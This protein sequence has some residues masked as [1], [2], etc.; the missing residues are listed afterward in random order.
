[1]THVCPNIQ[2][3]E[4]SVR[5]ASPLIGVVVCGM[6]QGYGGVEQLFSFLTPPQ[7]GRKLLNFR[8]GVHSL[9]FLF[10]WASRT[11]LNR[12][13]DRQPAVAYPPTV[14][15][16][17]RRPAVFFLAFRDRPEFKWQVICI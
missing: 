1:M 4:F 16:G 13:S 17:L 15:L 7:G 3:P 5:G 10:F 2:K 12:S 9:S 6:L 11:A 8:Q 14:E